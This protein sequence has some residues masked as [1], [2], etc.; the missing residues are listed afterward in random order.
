MYYNMY[1]GNYSLKKAGTVYSAALVLFVFLAIMFSACETKKAVISGDTVPVPAPSASNPDGTDASAPLKPFVEMV[2]VGGGTYRMGNAASPRRRDSSTLDIEWPLHYVTV[3]SFYIGKYEVT[4]GQY[5]EVTGIKPSSHMKN[6]DDAAPN[7]WMKL[8]VESVSWYDALVFCNLLSVKEKLMP[9]YS[10]EG[11]ADTDVWGEPPSRNSTVWNAVEM[12]RNADGYRLP[13]EAEWEYAARGGEE[14]RNYNYAGSNEPAH[15]AWYTLAN[16][17][18]IATIHEVGRKQPNEL[19]LYDMSGNVMEWCWDWLDT[20][21]SEPQYNPAGPSRGLY[22]VIRGGGWSVRDNYS[23]IAYRH[24][25][26]AHYYGINLGFRLARNI[27][28]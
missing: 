1:M 19:G 6:P 23:R 27:R 12:N 17:R 14:S 28:E 8:P 9:V 5:Y 3:R 13:T 21:P 4:Q 15:V 25:N 24:N 18:I 11:S 22:R 7:G 2:P 20:Y 16:S 10:I 26:Q